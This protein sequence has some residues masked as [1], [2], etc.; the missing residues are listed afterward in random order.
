[1]GFK[2]FF[3][4]SSLLNALLGELPVQTGKVFVLGKIAY[5]SQEP[6]LF[7]GTVRENIVFCHPFNEKKYQQVVK[8]MQC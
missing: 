6:W 4:Q 2:K 3:F 5:A 8:G 7:F 1:M